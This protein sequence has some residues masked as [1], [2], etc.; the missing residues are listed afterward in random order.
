MED[1][2]LGSPAAEQL[3]AALQPAY[4]FSAHLHVKFA[5]LVR[6]G[7]TADGA[8]LPP[9]GAGGAQQNGA[10]QGSA[11]VAAATVPRSTRFLALDKCLP[12]RRF[13][14]VTVDTLQTLTL[15]T[16]ASIVQH[17]CGGVM[18]QMIGCGP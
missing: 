12:R 1:G 18:R 7:V 15:R 6:H 10:A 8:T 2:S 3:L 16:Q 4:W 13:L 11:S 17:T 14:Q 9:P 5:A